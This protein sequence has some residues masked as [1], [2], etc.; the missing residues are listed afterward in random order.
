MF[1][2]CSSKQQFNNTLDVNNDNALYRSPGHFI[3][4][5]TS[6]QYVVSFL[7]PLDPVSVPPW[8]TTVHFSMDGVIQFHTT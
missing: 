4:E 1:F 3:P 8:D 7:V 6:L 2:L 5:R